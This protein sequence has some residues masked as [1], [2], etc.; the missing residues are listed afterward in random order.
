MLDFSSTTMGFKS[1]SFKPQPSLDDLEML[2]L[3]RKLQ[4][5]FTQHSKLEVTNYFTYLSLTKDML[6]EYSKF[7]KLVEEKMTSSRESS[8]GPLHA[9]GPSSSKSPHHSSYSKS[10][11]DSRR[12]YPH[13]S[14]SMSSS[15]TRSSSSSSSQSGSSSTSPKSPIP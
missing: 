3:A 12:H 4:C 11:R 13:S 10:Y 8:L 15:S 5:L 2:D 6:K 1:F 9:Y 7:E 14:S